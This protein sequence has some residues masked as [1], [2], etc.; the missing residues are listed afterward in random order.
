MG[1][2]CSCDIESYGIES[3]GY[4]KDLHLNKNIKTQNYVSNHTIEKEIQNQPGLV[5]E[6]YLNNG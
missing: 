6:Y 5:K 4:H 2:C 1:S 3:Y